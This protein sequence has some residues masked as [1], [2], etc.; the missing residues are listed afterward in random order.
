MS[1]FRVYFKEPGIPV[2]VSVHTAE[3]ARVMASRIRI[4]VY[5]VQKKLYSEDNVTYIVE[6]PA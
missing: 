2:V 4:A 6:L 3:R 5:P 1:R